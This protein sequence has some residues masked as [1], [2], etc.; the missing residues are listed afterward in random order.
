VRDPISFNGGQ[1]NLYAYAHNAPNFVTDRTG[2]DPSGDVQKIL[3]AFKKNVDDMT[4]EGLRDPDPYYNNRCRMAPW[5]LGCNEDNKYKDC[6]EQTEEMNKRFEKGSYQ[7]AWSFSMESGI[8]H[9]WGVA[10]SNNPENPYIYYDT[11]ADQISVDKP[12]D[13]CSGWFG[14]ADRKGPNNFP[15]GWGGRPR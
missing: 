13:A 14:E 3:D 9:A 12:C 7:D 11:R 8:G 5:S 2:L 10:L 1:L 4:R 6:G 15:P